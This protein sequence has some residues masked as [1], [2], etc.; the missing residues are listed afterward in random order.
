MDEPKRVLV[1]DGNPDSRR[2]VVA[3]LA[4]RPVKCDEASSAQQALELARQNL[5]D[6]IILDLNLPDLSGLALCRLVRETPSLERVPLLALSTRA[7][8]MDRIL[9]FEAGADDF[10]RRP[11][12][13]PELAVRAVAVL[14]GFEAAGASPAGATG[15]C[16]LSIDVRSGRAEVAGEPIDLTQK[17]FELLSTLVQQAGRVVRRRDLI[18]RLWGDAPPQSD[19]AV[20]AHIK[21][22]RRKLGRVRDCIETVRG[23]GYRFSAPPPD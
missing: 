8:E 12:Y 16:S 11:F 6:L 21:S 13:A 10:L 22:I 23:V 5:P 18:Q 7:G 20:D 2:Q 3:S 4:E 1:V 9:A 17:E 19:R 15:A 14:R